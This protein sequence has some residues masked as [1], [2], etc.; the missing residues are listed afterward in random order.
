MSKDDIRLL[1]FLSMNQAKR[2]L[3]INIVQLYLYI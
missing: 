1:H 3:L 2:P